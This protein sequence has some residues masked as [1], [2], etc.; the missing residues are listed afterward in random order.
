VR[1]RDER[2]QRGWKILAGIAVVILV[3]L[4]FFVAIEG[5]TGPGPTQDRS[6]TPVVALISVGVGA[7]LGGVVRAV[8]DRYTV[9]EESKGI[10][11]ALKAE[12]EAVLHLVQHREYVRLVSDCINRLENPTYM[13]T[14]KDVFNIGVTQ[15]YFPVFNALCP[16]IGLLGDLSADVVRLYTAGKALLE[17]MRYLTVIYERAQ[18][19]QGALDR[20]EL[21]NRSRDVASLFQGIL[22]AGPQAENALAA[23]AARRWWN[24]VP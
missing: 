19:R 12:I 14:L 7:L 20:E 10:A 16:K 17:D 22:A 2:A 5:I 4:I 24:I 3:L 18:S 21:L 15:E 6:A 13:P 9:F 11:V 8:V 23:Y 1:S